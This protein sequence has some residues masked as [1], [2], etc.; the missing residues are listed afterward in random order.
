MLSAKIFSRDEVA[1][2]DVLAAMAESVLTSISGDSK[3]R[4]FKVEQQKDREVSVSVGGKPPR[5]IFYRKT[6]TFKQ[7]FPNEVGR[8]RC[9]CASVCSGAVA[10]IKCMSCKIYDPTGLGYFC[11]MCFRHSHPWYRVPHIY[12]DIGRDESVEQALRVAHRKAEIVRY[13][14]DGRDT[15]ANVMSVEPKL[16]YLADDLKIETDMRDAGRKITDTVNRILT[17]QDQLR[18]EVSDYDNKVSKDSSLRRKLFS[19][20]A[21]GDNDNTVYNTRD[22]GS[23]NSVSSSVSVTS[24][25][26]GSLQSTSSSKSL[27]PKEE[28]REKQKGSGERKRSSAEMTA[29]SVILLQAFLRGCRAR[30]VISQAYADRLLRVFDRRSG[31]DFFHDRVT[32]G[33]SWSLPS[34]VRSCDAERIEVFKEGEEGGDDGVHRGRYD[35]QRLHWC[36]KRNAAPKNKPERAVIGAE[37]AARVLIGFGRC[38]LA[39]KKVL[40]AADARFSRIVQDANTIYY[41]N[42][43]TGDTFWSKP[44]VYLTTEP[45]LFDETSGDSSRR[46]P[47]VKRL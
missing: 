9:S 40:S 28:E 37:G 29:R 4:I 23:N 20:P 11:D 43:G 2:E 44:S 1:C 39:R 17:F 19:D 8:R 24:S 31:R 26:L 27:L 41:V 35:D 45:P 36:A 15:L 18:K 47:R 21:S 13:Q 10:T 16:E 22:G 6:V 33:S 30:Q 12:M 14:K 5:E 42:L 7:A 32:N 25:M 38:V 3:V 34:F 46:S